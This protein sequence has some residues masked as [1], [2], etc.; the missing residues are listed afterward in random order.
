MLLCV[1]VHAQFAMI[2]MHKTNTLCWAS[3]SVLVFSGPNRQFSQ[4]IIK[5]PVLVSGTWCH[6]R[7]TVTHR[8]TCDHK[9]D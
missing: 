1:S 2:V 4:I 9:D 8:N 6:L 7:M 5:L 3:V